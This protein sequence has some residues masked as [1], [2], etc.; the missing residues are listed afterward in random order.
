MSPLC[1]GVGSWLRTAERT[2]TL[3]RARFACGAVLCLTSGLGKTTADKKTKKVF[4]FCDIV[5]SKFYF[6]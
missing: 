5:L 3:A 2:G 1:A 4:L 6:F